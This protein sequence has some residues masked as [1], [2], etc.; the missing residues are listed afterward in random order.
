MHFMT[1]LMNKIFA[2][3]RRYKNL[4][5]LVDQQITFKTQI[6]S[7]LGSFVITLIMIALPM[8][9][10]I[11][12]FIYAKHTIFLSYIMLALLIVGVLLYFAIYYKLLKNYHQKLEEIN[13]KVPMLVEGIGVSLVVLIF[14]IIAIS[15]AL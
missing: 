14:G 11:N 5:K 2:F 13:T 7:V 15:V 10:T 12:M 8:L 1:F 4:V 3:F 9:I 6:K